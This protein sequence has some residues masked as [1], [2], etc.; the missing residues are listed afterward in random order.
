MRRD[1]GR[2]WVKK[3]QFWRDI[4]IE[5][6]DVNLADLIHGLFTVN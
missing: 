4:I 2:G 6:S 1:G 3:G 5:Q